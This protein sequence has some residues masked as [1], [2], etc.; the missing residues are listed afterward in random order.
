MLLSGNNHGARQI[1]EYQYDYRRI[2]RN[3][4]I[5]DCIQLMPLDWKVNDPLILRGEDAV[6]APPHLSPNVISMPAPP[7]QNLM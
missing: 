6:L 5:H 1:K 3:A 2:A 7:T 4:C